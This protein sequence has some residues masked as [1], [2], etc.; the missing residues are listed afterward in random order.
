MSAIVEYDT[1]PLSWVKGEIDH[2]LQQT[3]DTLNQFRIGQDDPAL[4]RNART[5]LNQ[6]SGAIEMV[7]LQGVALLSQETKKLLEQLESQA[8]PVDAAAFDLLQRTIDAICLY[9]DDLIKGKP[10]LELR[11]FPLYQEIRAALGVEHSAESDLFFPDLG[12][13][14]PRAQPAVPRSETELAALVKKSR[15]QFQRG[16]LAFLRQQNADQGLAV[17]RTAVHD[18]EQ[19]MTLPANRTLWWGATAFVDCLSNHAIE[20]NFA[21][22]QL[23]GRIDLQMRRQAEGSYKVAERLLK[24]ILY[25]VAKSR[26]VSDHVKAVKQA[27]ALDHM[28]PDNT[29]ESSAMAALLPLLKELRNLLAP[30]KESWLK[31]TAGNRDSLAQFQSQ[32]I[33]LLARTA[34]LKSTPLLNL[35]AQISEIAASAERLPEGQTEALGLEV[36]TAL[37]LIQNTLENYQH[38]TGELVAQADVQVQRLRAAAYGDVDVTQ[39]PEIPLLDEMSRHAQERLLI[40]QVAQE[41]Q[42]NLQQTEEVLDAFFRDPQHGR[43]ALASI[44]APLAQVQGALNILQLDEASRLLTAAHAIVLGFQDARRPINET[45]FAVIADALSS[46]GLYI[47][48][49]RHQRNGAGTLLLPALRQLGLAGPEPATSADLQ[50]ESPAPSVED[51]LDALKHDVRKQLNAWQEAP[52]EAHTQKKFLSALRELEEDAE[53][54]GDYALK[55]QTADALKLAGSGPNPALSQAI[56]DISGGESAPQQSAIEASADATINQA[57]DAELLEVFL[58][59]AG[60]VLDSIATHLEM[61]RAEP[62]NR[63]SLTTLRRNFHTLKGSGRMVGLT[64][65]GEVAWSIEQLLNQW[66]QD[67]K[68]ASAALLEVLTDAHGRFDGWI[69]SLKSSGQAHIAADALVTK[70]ARLRSGELP[71]PTPAQAELPPAEHHVTPQPAD[72]VHDLT[73]APGPAP[74]PAIEASQSVLADIA[75]TDD[76]S[77]P[78][79]SAADI[80]G[81]S[82]AA[83]SPDAS[84]A[85]PEDDRVSI[86]TN[87]ISAPLLDIFLREA[88]QHHTTLRREFAHLQIN[89]GEP[90]AYDFMRAAH[91]LAGIAGT[92]GFTAV[93]DLAHALEAW[94]TQLHESVATLP[95]DSRLTDAAITALGEMLDSINAQRAPVPAHDL[96][97]ALVAV[98]AATLEHEA[99]LSDCE[100]TGNEPEPAAAS[101]LETGASQA[102]T[103]RINPVN[104]AEPADI[105]HLN[106]LLAAADEQQAR[107]N[108]VD[109]L[110]DQLL[111]IFLEEAAELMPKISAESRNWRADPARGDAPAS[112]QRLLHTLKGSARMAG[113]MRL[114]EL[115]HIMETRVVNALESGA[116]EAAYF[117]GFEIEL[118]RL[119]DALNRLRHTDA[120]T[121]Q[122]ETEDTHAALQDAPHALHAHTPAKALIEP[123]TSARMLRVRADT[124]DRLV[125]EAGEISITRSRLESSVSGIKQNAGELAENIGRLRAQL[126]E[127]EI[128]AESQMQSTLSHMHKDDHQFDPLEFDRFTRL[129]ELTRMIAESINDVGTVQQN[130]AVGLNETEA[131]LT[132]Q[133]RMTRDLQQALM[134][135]RIVPLASVADRLHRTVRR[136][137]KDMGKKASLQIIGEQVEMDRSVL[138]KMVAPFEHLLRNAVAHGLELPA[139]R[140]QAGKSEYGEIVLHARQEGN[141]VMLS[142][143]DDGRGLNLDAI[144]ARA[145]AKGLLQ[146]GISVAPNQL[147]QFIFAPGFST[148]EA[149]TELSGRGIGMDVVKSEITGLGGRLEVASEAGKGVQFMVYLPLTLAVTQTVLITAGDHLYALPSTMV[150]QVQEYKSD[151]LAELLAAGTIEWQGNRYDLFYLPH[152]LGQTD[153]VH[154]AQRY[155]AVILLRSGTQR[156]AILVDELTGNREVVVKNIGPQ[157]ARVSGI[158][159]ATVLGNGQVVLIL[160]PVQLA[161]RQGE[162]TGTAAVQ[163]P[164]I[165]AA[166]ARVVMV[167]DDSLTVRKITGRLLA[168]EGYEVITAKDGLDALQI[169]QDVIPDVMLLDIEMPRMDGFEL[170]KAMRADAQL[171][172]VPIIMITSRTA[173]KHRDHALSL[174]V[175]AYLGKPFQEEQLLAH[176][177]RYMHQPE[178]A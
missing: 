170:T 71:E 139:E 12:Q 60:E 47:D 177:A 84:I 15:A 30:A 167:V 11:L 54:I 65:L 131:A 26:A 102:S 23:C 171:A 134:H 1:G 77:V 18:I 44:N 43:Q 158:A 124:V 92:T 137:A 34:E 157:L 166:R 70:A 119:G 24:D 31:F 149:V 161:L 53:L 69:G 153:R 78:D 63:A 75:V 57:I 67:E 20:P 48:A 6:V 73:F 39:I 76:L 108:I 58:E 143:R 146:P 168:R 133:A 109:D 14:A 29:G 51:S 175:N 142:L 8:L 59:E 35:L 28:M 93:A 50:A 169:L 99:Q 45:D 86:G 13:R 17:M 144:H 172:G 42:S 80:S 90:V 123:E 27:F 129:Q 72:T 141:E 121:A 83:E 145:I 178:T 130:I 147:M 21:V 82:P 49:L 91:T 52:A 62:H 103:T 97:A 176:V 104:I 66:L 36:A 61:C 7:G 101:V 162:H 95:P 120:A 122:I 9:L 148:A 164:V 4:L 155:N 151:T 98:Q 116:L 128:Q 105:P 173:D 74:E 94:L 41:V 125:N 113:A 68:S 135:I 64:D 156:C 165:E 16:L 118:D 140:I 46:L 22:K 19:A 114:G 174:G 111:P 106:T 85:P 55:Q 100:A 163:A 10:N 138:E 160:N 88:E 107:R 150:E 132:Q 3:R 37:L 40:A 87:L 89:P 5:Y 152:L 159:G 56:Q 112:L 2:A 110:D 96:I 81:I 33:A 127:L 115:T 32:I 25:F 136:A 38:V 117:D 126:R 79:V 154:L